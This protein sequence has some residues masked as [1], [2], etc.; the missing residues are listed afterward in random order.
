M[1]ARPISFEGGVLMQ[2]KMHSDMAEKTI[3]DR[4]VSLMFVCALELRHYDDS[5]YE[6]FVVHS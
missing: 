6:S 2:I 4:G 1:D 5:Q 3:Y